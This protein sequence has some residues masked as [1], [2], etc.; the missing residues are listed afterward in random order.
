M[1][2]RDSAYS[3]LSRVMQR[4][5]SPSEF[6]NLIQAIN[7]GVKGLLKGKYDVEAVRLAAQKICMMI[8][9]AHSKSCAAVESEVGKD[10]VEY[11]TELITNTVIELALSRGGGDFATFAFRD[12]LGE[13]SSKTEVSESEGGLGFLS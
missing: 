5:L 6:Y 9:A 11:C 13:K 1:S 8:K 3:E 12:V 10:F 7:T 4:I 2:V